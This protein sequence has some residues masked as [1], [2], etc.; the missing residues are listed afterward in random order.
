VVN[1]RPGVPRREVRRLRAILHRARTEGLEA[2][3]K[4]GRPHFRAWLRGMI[5]YVGMARPE[6]GARLLAEF[7]ALAGAAAE[8][9]VPSGPV[10]GAPSPGSAEDPPE[11]R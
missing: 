1:D 11:S 5:A 7:R 10:A 9:G 3:N 8:A 2:Q 4:E 6:A